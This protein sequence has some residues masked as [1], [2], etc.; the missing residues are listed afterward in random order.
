MNNFKTT[1]LAA[2]V[3]TLAACGQSTPEQR[4]EAAGEALEDTSS[5]LETVTTRIDETEALL[6]ELRSKKRKLTNKVRTL[7][8]RVA[9]RATDV[10]LFR[11]VQGALLEN[12]ALSEAAIGVNVDDGEV[13][14]RGVVRTQQQADTAVALAQQT[15]GVERVRSRIQI[16]DP[17]AGAA[18]GA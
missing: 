7:E 17:A 10:A 14:L 8:Q 1:W 13:T 3:L 2:I 5:E 11:A 15:A 12:D 9:A 18:S 16:D 6:D 4:L